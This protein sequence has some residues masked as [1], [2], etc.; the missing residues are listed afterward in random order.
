MNLKFYDFFF[1]LTPKNLSTNK[2]IFSCNEF[3]EFDYFYE[4]FLFI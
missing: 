3:K 1:Y 2:Y 4:L